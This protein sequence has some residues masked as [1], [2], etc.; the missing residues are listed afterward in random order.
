[1]ETP[2]RLEAQVPLP[3]GERNLVED[4][5][6]SDPYLLYEGIQVAQSALLEDKCFDEAFFLGTPRKRASD[7]LDELE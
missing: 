4:C 6:S 3:S 5:H 1:M 7:L 2:P